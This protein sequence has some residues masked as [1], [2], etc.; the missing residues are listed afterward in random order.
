MKQID[1]H[2]LIKLRNPPGDH[3]EWKG[4]WGDKSGLWTK[5][6]KKKVGF[7]DEDDNTFWYVHTSWFWSSVV[8]CTCIDKHLL[9]RFHT[10]CPLMTSVWLSTPCTS[11]VGTTPIH[12]SPR[13]Y[14]ELGRSRIQQRRMILIHLVVYL[15]GEFRKGPYWTCMVPFLSKLMLHLWTHGVC[16]SLL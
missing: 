13:I 10:G 8:V 15:R 6:Y 7:T 16:L 11:V 2:Q 9:Y 4:D 1:E 5:R 14:M 12:G 3:E